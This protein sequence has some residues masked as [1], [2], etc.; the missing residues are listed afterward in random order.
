MVGSGIH[1][2]PFKRS[3]LRLIF[4]IYDQAITL[5]D[6]LSIIAQDVDIHENGTLFSIPLSLLYVPIS[7]AWYS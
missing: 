2:K 1:N 3:S 4:A 7:D 5:L 6:I